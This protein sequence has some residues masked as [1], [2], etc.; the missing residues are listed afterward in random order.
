[1]PQMKVVLLGN[2]GTG[3]TCIFLR[4]ARGEFYDSTE[5]TIGAA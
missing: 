2:A 3:K 4:F 1:M 5:A